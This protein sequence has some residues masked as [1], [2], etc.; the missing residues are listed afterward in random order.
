MSGFVTMASLSS[1][2]KPPRTVWQLSSQE[3]A[4]RSN[5]RARKPYER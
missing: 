3:S 5:E 4:K 2:T 1:K